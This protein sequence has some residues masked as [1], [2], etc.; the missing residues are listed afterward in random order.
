MHQPLTPHLRQ[1]RAHPA[2][3][4][5]GRARRPGRST[6]NPNTN[7][8]GFRP[9]QRLAVRVLERAV[10]DVMDPTGSIDDR[11]SARAFL[12]GS[13]MLRHWCHVAALDADC[14]A[15][16]VTRFAAQAASIPRRVHEVGGLS[17]SGD[18]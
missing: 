8:E 9:Y 2:P 14:I 1:C 5:A 15:E 16:R 17:Q 10:L 6:A 13:I 18:L 11:N 12:S 4:A 3:A 7:D